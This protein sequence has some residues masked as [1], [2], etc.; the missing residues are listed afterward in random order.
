MNVLNLVVLA[1]TGFFVCW[2]LIP[3]I[4][5]WSIGVGATNQSR[6]YHH[7][8]KLAVPR[9]GGIALAS[10]FLVVAVLTFIF[11]GETPERTWPN[12]A[13]IIGSLA[14]FWLG[15]WDDV[16]PLGARG[17]RFLAVRPMSPPRS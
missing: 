1:L 5:R 4:C 15:L 13:L 16:R 2:G 8:H 6:Q 3:L 17:S 12:I 9:L 10:A 14:M 7:T 11:F